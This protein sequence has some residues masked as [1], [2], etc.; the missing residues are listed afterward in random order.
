MSAR[1]V[2]NGVRP[3]LDLHGCTVNQAVQ[4]TRRLILESVRRGRDSIRLIHGKSTTTPGQRTIKSALTDLM[5]HQQLPM[6]VSSVY[7]SD[8][9]MIVALRR[10]GS[11]HAPGRISLRDLSR[12]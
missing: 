9:H 4:L 10:R 6:H 8:G 12:I 5:D 11:T 3:E 1:L 7:K 2:D